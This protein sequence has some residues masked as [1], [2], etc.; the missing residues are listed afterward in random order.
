M[1]DWSGNDGEMMPHSKSR[2]SASKRLW[3]VDRD[4][5]C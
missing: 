2:L 3:G 5:P 1:S 4:Y